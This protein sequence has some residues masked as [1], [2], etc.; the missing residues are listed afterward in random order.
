MIFFALKFF[1]FIF[2]VRK[3]KMSSFWGR[4][5]CQKSLKTSPHTCDSNYYI[6]DYL[7]I[8][9]PELLFRLISPILHFQDKREFGGSAV[10]AGQ[11]VGFKKDLCLIIIP[12]LLAL[13][14]RWQI[15]VKV[16]KPVL[17]WFQI[18]GQMYPPDPTLGTIF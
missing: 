11:E 12:R 13:V 4:T 18:L 8:H 16:V 6:S 9:V 3:T 7:F 10:R 17:D 2:L 15:W 5:V 1:F 14:V